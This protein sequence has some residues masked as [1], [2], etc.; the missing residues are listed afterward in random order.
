MLWFFGEVLLGYWFGFVV[1]GG[2]VEFIIEVVVGFWELVGE[3]VYGVGGEGGDEEDEG[4]W[5]VGLFWFFVSEWLNDFGM[6]DLVIDD[7]MIFYVVD[8]LKEGGNGV[9]MRWWDG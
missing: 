5:E 2:E 1:G 9:V 4:W 7:L 6:K 3:V 8:E